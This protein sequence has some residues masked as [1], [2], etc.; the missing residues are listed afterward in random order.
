MDNPSAFIILISLENVRVADSFPCLRE[1]FT[2]V[3][4]FFF[5]YIHLLFDQF[6]ETDPEL[7]RHTKKIENTPTASS[8]DKR[9]DLLE[10]VIF[11]LCKMFIITV[12]LRFS[13]DWL[14]RK[15]SV[16]SV[17]R[18]P[19]CQ[20]RAPGAGGHVCCRGQGAERWHGN[21]ILF[22]LIFTWRRSQGRV[23]SFSYTSSVARQAAGAECDFNKHL[24]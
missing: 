23:M 12:M 22:Q 9:K 6:T 17:I 1:L 24:H 7:H 14:W 4:R 13:A 20:C 5:F 18:I 21:V 16:S 2:G 11:K 10:P 15:I 3:K 19:Y 8:T